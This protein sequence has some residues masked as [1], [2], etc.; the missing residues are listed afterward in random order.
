M[1]TWVDGPAH[2]GYPGYTVIFKTRLEIAVIITEVSGSAPADLLSPAPCI[3]LF[4]HHSIAFTAQ[5]E[6]PAVFYET[7]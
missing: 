5:R 2:V 1:V 3:L 4:R 6:A 7:K